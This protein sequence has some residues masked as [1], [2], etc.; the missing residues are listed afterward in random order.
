M[1]PTP[2]NRPLSP[3]LQVYKPQ[4]TSILSISHRLTGLI[5]SAGAVMLVMWLL[6]IAFDRDFYDA[7]V[8]SLQTML[9]RAALVVW[10][11]SFYYHLGNG[12]RHLFWDAGKGFELKSV[13]ASGYAVVIF[14]IAATVLTWGVPL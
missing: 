7:L 10:V 3:H 12:I 1:N 9:G 14:A 4:L 6:G 2:S 11:F 13:Y 8:I 5:L